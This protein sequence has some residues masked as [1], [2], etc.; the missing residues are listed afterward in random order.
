MKLEEINNGTKD[1]MN[2]LIEAL[3]AGHSEVLD[4]RCPYWS[5][6]EEVTHEAEALT[7]ASVLHAFSIL[8]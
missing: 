1:A 8:P 7:L 2:H 3:E 5:P 4:V 6:S